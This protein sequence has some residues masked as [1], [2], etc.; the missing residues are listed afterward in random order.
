MPAFMFPGQ[1]SQRP[2]MGRA[3]RG[4][5]SWEIVRDASSATGR[6]VEH[7][8][9]H[10]DEAE[11]TET[12]NAQLATFTLSLVVLDAVERLGIEP[13]VS[14]GHSLGEYTAL[15][16]AGAL[17]L[18]DG[19]RL[20]AERGE[21]MQG[22][23]DASPGVM[24][25]VAGTDAETADIACR[26]ADGQVWLANDN[27]PEEVV[28]AG[29]GESVQR[30]SWEAIRLGARSL[31]PVRVG[32]A[33]HTPSMSPARDRLRK[34]IRATTF[35]DAD[36]PVITNVD[37]RSHTVATEWEQLL[38]T[39]LTAPV[40]WRQSVLRMGGLDD[41]D[42]ELE[43]L[44]V[45]IGPGSALSRLVAQTLPGVRTVPMSAP[46]DLDRLVD[47][48]AGH[49]T[50]RS[51]AASH[52]GEVLTVSERL[53]IS[54]CVGIWAPD[55]DAA[56]DVDAPIEVGTL[57]GLV[58]GTEVRSPFAGSVMGVLAHPDERVQAGQPIAWLRAR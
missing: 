51:F 44:F 6:D 45:E 47:A 12:R 54:P 13:T 58:A 26:L 32:G 39:Q 35:H 23:A 14:A 48:V 41:R 27:S 56:L 22:A 4:H 20:V 31:A 36:V 52:A 8:L 9:L 30:A 40:R 49:A 21:A 57:L 53:V 7:L 15:V 17:G 24:S 55:P 46:D 38:M 16:S 29:D 2:G 18:E 50:R 43:R 34:A 28:I 19:F 25:K 11:L 33:F 3:W 5:E 10:A 42:A 1:G 37:A